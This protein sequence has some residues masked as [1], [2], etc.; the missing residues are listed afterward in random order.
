MIRIQII[1]SCKTDALQ[2]IGLTHKRTSKRHRL[3]TIA[4]FA[5]C[6]NYVQF[7]AVCEKICL[8]ELDESESN[9]KD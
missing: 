4:F 8:F 6:V 2:K 9:C 3:E 7:T 5:I 1:Y